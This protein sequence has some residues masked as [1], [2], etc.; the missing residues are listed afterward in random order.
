[1]GHVGMAIGVT[2]V[3]AQ[4]DLAD[5]G[6]VSVDTFSHTN[7]RSIKTTLIVAPVAATVFP[8]TRRAR[9]LE[10]PL[11]DELAVLPTVV[12]PV[13]VRP[14]V[15][16]DLCAFVVEVVS[17]EISKSHSSLPTGRVGL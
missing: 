10:K 2:V 16:G 17:K 14:Y 4:Y 12:T 9:A 6:W 3:H 11:E 15:G 7:P 5:G 8:L 1:M 13:R